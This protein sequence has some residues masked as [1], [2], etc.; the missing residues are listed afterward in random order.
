MGGGNMRGRCGVDGVGGMQRGGEGREERLV[1]V[2]G[3]LVV[4]SEG[5]E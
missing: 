2:V 3:V 1:L 5:Q 4:L